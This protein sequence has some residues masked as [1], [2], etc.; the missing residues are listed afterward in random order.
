MDYQAETTVQDRM[1]KAFIISCTQ[2]GDVITRVMGHECR[3]VK[4]AMDDD[5]SRKEGRKERGCNSYLCPVTSWMVL[6]R[7]GSPHGSD[8]VGIVVIIGVSTLFPDV[9]VLISSDVCAYSSDVFIK[10]GILILL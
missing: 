6:G 8:V 9:R 5:C 10:S 3:R 4:G 2:L 7:E 1:D